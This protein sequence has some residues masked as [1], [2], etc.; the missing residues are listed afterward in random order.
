MLI[1]RTVTRTLLAGAIVVSLFP[2]VWMLR[3]AF[4]P[5]DEVYFSGLQLFPT[6]LT[7]ENFTRALTESHLGNSLGVGVLVTLSILVI[8]LM[9]CIPA[10][11]VLAKVPMRGKSFL[12]ALVL[13]G[14]L[15]PSQ[16][17]LVPTFLGVNLLGLG[18][19]VTGLVLP[20]MTSSFGI[21][22]L[23]QQIM[24]IPDSLLEAAKADGLSPWRT[25]MSVVVPLA[26]PG[27]AAF[28]V[29][30][31][32]VHWNDYLWPLLIAR[33]P[34]I[35]TP[36]L[37]LAQFQQAD[38]GFDYAALSAAAVIVTAPVVVLFLVAQRQFVQ[39]MSGSE[40]PG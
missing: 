23:R 34:E 5:Q 2:F 3:T 24:A 16:V 6:S 38:V 33:S 36:P 15:V 26:A 13:G 7:F 37:A 19:T 17:T 31:V 9:T 32:F 11:Y 30:S 28:S 40:A 20:F 14:L 21:F 29:F 25:L 4:A 8:Q 10:A 27:I 35:A 39:G 18:D 1:S 12:L 22:L